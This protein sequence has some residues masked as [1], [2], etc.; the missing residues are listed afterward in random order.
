MIKLAV[1]DSKGV[2]DVVT[3]DYTTIHHY[4]KPETSL[5]YKVVVVEISVKYEIRIYRS[6][7][8]TPYDMLD[9]IGLEKWWRF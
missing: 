1:L 3:D 5:G 8:E 2:I 9:V 7:H 6:C 4:A